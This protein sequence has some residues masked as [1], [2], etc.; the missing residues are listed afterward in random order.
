MTDSETCCA[1]DDAFPPIDRTAC[2][3]TRE[4]FS[5][6]RASG[7][8][9][10]LKAA[11][12]GGMALLA[13]CGG[14]GPTPQPPMVTVEAPISRDVGIYY[15][16]TGTTRAVASVE[17]Q[18]R[19]TGVLE[20]MY[21][22][23][24]T[25]VR[26]GQTL[27][28]IEPDQYEALRDE[29]QAALNSARAEAARTE[30]DLD[31]LEVAI[32]TNAVSES[33]VDRARAL[34]DQAL[35]AVASA[36]ARLQR[37]QLDVDYTRVKTPISGQVSRNLVDLG[38]LVSAQQST[39]L[40]TVNQITPIHV[41]FDAPE[42][43]VLDLLNRTNRG[44]V[45][46]GGERVLRP[47]G[48][49]AGAQDLGAV[50]RVE[51]ATEVDD[52]YAHGGQIDYIDNTVNPA[53]G[54]IQLRGVLPNQEFDLFPGLFVRVRVTGGTVHGALLVREVGIGRD[55]GGNYVLVVGADNVVERR[56]VTLGDVQDDGYVV[57]EDG[58]EG[59]ERY[60]TN[61]LLRARPGLAVTPQ[62]PEGSSDTGTGDSAPAP[63]GGDGASDREG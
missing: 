22:D 49:G 7:S 25:L 9:P 21:F 41:Y 59:S 30:S 10:A 6:G 24:S 26:A 46:E 14:G 31:R 57:I 8:G 34:R 44:I 33:D 2:G 51:V 52:G 55:L 47:E 36:E 50:G 58:L 35:A 40:T 3:G 4:R 28:L 38:N 1:R 5:R 17:I 62:A 15:Y 63:A 54:T 61:G 43:L 45:T 56:Y 32:R 37:A 11:V 29:A 16:F 42:G 48:A 18:A 19:V 27:F 13:A 60:I 12:V 53:T 20:E 23:P 39:A